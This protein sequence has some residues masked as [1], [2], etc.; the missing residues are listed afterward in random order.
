[1]SSSLVAFAANPLP[2][3][4]LVVIKPLRNIIGTSTAG[5]SAGTTQP[6]GTISA[7]V[8][9]QTTEI[10]ADAVVRERHEDELVITENPVE[11]GSVVA[12]N[13]YKLPAKLELT[14]GWS[15]GSSENATGDPQ[16]LNNLYQQ[17]LGL[18]VNRILCTV[19]TGKRVYNNMLVQRILAQSDQDNENVLILE[20][21]M[22]EIIMASTQIVSTSLPTDPT[23]HLFPDQTLPTVPRGTVSLQP[24]PN[25]NVTP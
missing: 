13:A 4:S 6:N 9:T 24:A 17:M 18:Q 8:Q 25:F 15:I 23:A 16:F 21:A 11:T 14:Y 5:S 19:N 20:I 7:N 22:Q 12:D 10:V 2:I 3:P 1:M